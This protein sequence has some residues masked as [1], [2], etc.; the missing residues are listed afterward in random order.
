MKR[1]LFFAAI[2]TLAFL[3]AVGIQAVVQAQDSAPMTEDH[4]RRIRSNCIKAQ[5]T[6]N[7]LHASDALLR[8]NR[9]QLYE[10]L[11][12][13]LMT[14]LNTRIGLNKLDNTDL[15]AVSSQYDR[16]LG[17]FRVNYQQYEEAMSK[18]LK[19]NCTNQPVAFYDSVAD[20]RNKRAITHTSTVQLHKTIQDYKVKFEEFAN[21]FKE[22]A[23]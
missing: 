2:I 7:Q 12:T 14:P 11:A 1:P 8:V 19:I 10:S 13:K 21:K 16:Q 6:L 20:T 23:Q 5:T 3:G 22:I 18:T 17:E 15:T 4:I 9:G